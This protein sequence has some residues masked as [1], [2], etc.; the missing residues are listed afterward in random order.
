MTE[1]RSVLHHGKIEVVFPSEED[2]YQT[3]EITVRMRIPVES[4][5]K[6]YPG[7]GLLLAFSVGIAFWAAFYFLV[8]R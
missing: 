7:I 2:V 4:Q 6:R 8:L 5:E 3:D 1:A